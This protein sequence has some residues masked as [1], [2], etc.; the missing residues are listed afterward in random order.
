MTP[1]FWKPE[2]FPEFWMESFVFMLCFLTRELEPLSFQA[3]IPL[4]NLFAVDT[5]SG[6]SLHTYSICSFSGIFTVLNIISVCKALKPINSKWQASICCFGW[7]YIW[8]L[9]GYQMQQ[10]QN[11]IHFFPPSLPCLSWFPLFHKWHHQGRSLGSVISLP[12][13]H[14]CSNSQRYPARTALWDTLLPD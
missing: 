11:R 9:L 4:P 7:T 5:P 12:H 3:V 2:V 8:I 10:V 13:S 6:L 14:G 1:P